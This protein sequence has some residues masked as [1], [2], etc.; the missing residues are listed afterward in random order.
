M[1]SLGACMS[2]SL[3]T[4]VS[5][6]C[7]P[8]TPRGAMPTLVPETYLRRSLGRGT[9]G[10]RAST[11][12]LLNELIDTDTY[13]KASLQGADLERRTRI[14]VYTHLKQRFGARCIEKLSCRFQ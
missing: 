4:A 6:F 10:L 12:R 2:T 11:S 1:R 5:E 13:W 7:C 3:P 8:T 9:P 14:I